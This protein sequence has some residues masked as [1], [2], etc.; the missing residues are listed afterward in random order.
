MSTLSNKEWPLQNDLWERLLKD[1][2]EAFVELYRSYWGLL[3]KATFNFLQD[4]EQSMD[5]V[6]E[7]FTWLWEHRK[8]LHI[9]TSLK[10]YLLA[11]VKFKTANVI[12]DGKIQDRAYNRIAEVQSLP[13]STEA[14]FQLEVKELEDLIRQTVDAFPGKCKAV[15]E[16]SRNENLSNREIAHQLGI[17]VKTVES[18]MTIALRRLRGAVARMFIF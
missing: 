12:R 8:Q 3:Y 1:D 10:G 17:S 6:Q 13:D 14:G 15:Y 18:Q 2:K 4:R 11:A 16:L 7:V 9:K 5:V